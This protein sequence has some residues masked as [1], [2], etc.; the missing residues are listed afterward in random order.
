LVLATSGS[1]SLKAVMKRQGVSRK[2][3]PSLA[4]IDFAGLALCHRMGE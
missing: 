4:G 1:F 3:P 2:V